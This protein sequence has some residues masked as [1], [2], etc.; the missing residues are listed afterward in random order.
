MWICEIK[1]DQLTNAIKICCGFFIQF[2]NDSICAKFQ[3]KKNALRDIEVWNMQFFVIVL[4]EGKLN[5]I[6][7]YFAVKPNVAHNIAVFFENAK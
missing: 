3:Q 4:I 6:F 7:V 1:T 5:L 2:K